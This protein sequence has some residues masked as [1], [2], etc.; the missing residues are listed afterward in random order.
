MGTITWLHLLTGEKA[1]FVMQYGHQHT[2]SK[3]KFRMH[4]MCKM[5]RYRTQSNTKHI[6]QKAALSS[7]DSSSSF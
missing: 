2:I 7:R 3:T 5:K 1:D 6:Q 4:L